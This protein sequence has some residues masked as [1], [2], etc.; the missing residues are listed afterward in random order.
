MNAEQLGQFMSA[1]QV[2][3]VAV[4]QLLT[5]MKTALSGTSSVQQSQQK[6]QDEEKAIKITQKL[7]RR[8]PTLTITTAHAAPEYGE[9]FWLS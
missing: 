9:C 7:Q 6:L 5:D 3:Q 2:Q 4:V 1:M 8:S